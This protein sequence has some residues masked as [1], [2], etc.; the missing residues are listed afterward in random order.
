MGK[1]ILWR[2]RFRRLGLY[3]SG[4]YLAVYAIVIPAVGIWNATR[5][6][7]DPSVHPHTLCWLI[8]GLLVGFLVIVLRN[9]LE[10]RRVVY[11]PHWALNFQDRFDGM[12]DERSNAAKIL[13]DRKAE[14]GNIENPG[15][16]GI[17]DVLDFLDDVGLYQRADQISPELAH[18]HFFHWTRGYWQAAR[19]YIEAWRK[20][21][22]ARWN[23]VEELFETGCDIELGEHGGK[24]AQ[25]ILS[26]ADLSRFL[27]EE[28]MSGAS[29]TGPDA[30]EA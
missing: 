16:A 3:L 25:L 19:T 1:S 26:E 14:L 8:A 18:H 30:D 6:Q 17:N 23:H 15:L 21:E 11:D 5:S 7:S 27:M 12:G 28:E 9:Y 2:T 10:Y 4:T 29:P 22:P 20:K 13:R 24:R